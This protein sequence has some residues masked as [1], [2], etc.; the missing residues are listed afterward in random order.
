MTEVTETSLAENLAAVRGRI[1]DACRA[2]NRD[3]AAVLLVAVTKYAAPEQVREAIN[4][5]LTDLGENRVPQLPQRAAQFNEYLARRRTLGGEGV[6]PDKI[7][8][9]MVGRLQRNKVKQVLPHAAL[10]HSVDS[11]RLAEEIDEQAA[12][13]GKTQPVLLQVNCSDEAQK[14]GVAVGAATH[15]AREVASMENVRLA[16][17]MTMAAIDADEQRARDTF[18]RLREIFEEIE[19]L[20]VGGPEFRH[21]SMGMSNDLAPAIA[22]GATIVRVGGALFGPPPAEDEGDDD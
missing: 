17:L 5:G 14:G 9:H 15:L 22:E 2:A 10:I 4:L 16:G 13:I 21:L 8:W 20:E 19:K 6:V 1:A 11:L 3:P 12:R 7:R 18:N